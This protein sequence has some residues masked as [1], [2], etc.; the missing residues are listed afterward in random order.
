M[1]GISCNHPDPL[2]IQFG[3]DSEP[4]YLTL[5]VLNANYPVFYMS[6]RPSGQ[7]EWRPLSSK[8]WNYFVGLEND[9][10]GPIVDLKV[11]CTVG[12]GEVVYLEN[13][14]VIAGQ[15]VFAMSNC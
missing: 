13:I 2:L 14:S 11:D 12:G 6:V 7:E 10:L 5:Q 8:T 3:L 15:R 4:T 1:E 9:D